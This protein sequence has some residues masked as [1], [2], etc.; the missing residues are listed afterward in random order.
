MNQSINVFSVV[1]YNFFPTFNKLFNA[2]IVEIT[3]FPFEEIVQ[4]SLQFHVIIEWNAMQCIR[5]GSKQ[6]EIRRQM[7]KGIEGLLRG[8]TH[9]NWKEVRRGE[10]KVK[11]R[12]KGSG[13][14]NDL[15]LEEGEIGH[16]VG[17]IW[18]MW[19]HFP[20]KHL[21]SFLSHTGNVRAGI[22]MLQKNAMLPISGRFCWIAALSC[23][24]CWT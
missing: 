13:W 21:N 16:Q 20:A 11:E 18:R 10:R 7:A 3:W 17:R 6:M 14:R 4:P 19:Q 5:E 9:G 23:C 1:V 15:S 12:I 2:S 24:I 8:I 22:V